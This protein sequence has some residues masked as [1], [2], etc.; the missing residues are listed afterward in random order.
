MIILILLIVIISI[1]GVVMTM[2]LTWLHKSRG[3]P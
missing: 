2:D 3:V 1:M